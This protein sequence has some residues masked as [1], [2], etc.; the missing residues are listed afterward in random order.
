MR[1][2]GK[3][4]TR[5]LRIVSDHNGGR[6]WFIG[7][8]GL[9]TSKARWFAQ[10]ELNLLEVNSTFYRLPGPRQ[11][12]AWLEFPERISFVLK[13]SKYVTHIKRLKEPEEGVARFLEAVAPLHTR[14]RGYLVQLPPT[15]VYNDTN[16][17]RLNH[18]YSLLPSR[19]KDVF[20]E[21][22]D[23]SWHND[24]VYEW[25]MRKKWVIAGT[26][27]NKT[28]GT[29]YM[30]NMPGGLVMPGP[31]TTD[32][33]Y[34][35]LHGGKG[36]RGSYGSTQLQQL[37]DAISARGCKQNFVVF[38]NT[39]FS[40]RNQSCTKNGVELKFA[41]VCNAVTLGEMV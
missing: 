40:N 39:F 9:M 24:A 3:P 35:R 36:F 17:A 11:I 5:K 19:S 10:P 18:L 22:R 13:M 33:C 29:K 16:M 20:V 1:S 30:G 25:F 27:I 2:G 6:E 32:A 4:K 31:K 12:N 41:A 28:E 34:V 15:F 38:N 14:T 23:P 37:K 26:W 21:F 8:A 7:T